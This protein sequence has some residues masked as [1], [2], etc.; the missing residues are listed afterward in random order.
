MRDQTEPKTI[1][2]IEGVEGMLKA[3]HRWI[4]QVNILRQ[5]RRL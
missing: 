2:R 3:L 5:S 1:N 4:V